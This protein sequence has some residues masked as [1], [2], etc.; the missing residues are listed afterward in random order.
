MCRFGLSYRVAARE[1]K[2]SLHNGLEFR[3][4]PCRIFRVSPRASCSNAI[5]PF[6]PPVL[7]GLLARKRCNLP[8]TDGLLQLGEMALQS[9]NF[10]PKPALRSNQN[11]SVPVQ[12]VFIM[13]GKGV[14]Q[15][16]GSTA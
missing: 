7:E 4:K 11:R 5:N 2:L 6:P 10:G 13:P 12:V 14:I 3:T 8:R 9:R 15:G 1:F 16:E